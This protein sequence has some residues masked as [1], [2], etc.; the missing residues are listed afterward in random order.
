MSNSHV[1][2]VMNVLLVL[3]FH[4]LCIMQYNRLVF[5]ISYFDNHEFE[6]HISPAM[7]KADTNLEFRFIPNKLV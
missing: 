4:Y 1:Y 6:L 5:N 2:F 7:T 3:A